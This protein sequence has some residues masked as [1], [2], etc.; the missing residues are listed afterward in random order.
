MKIILL[1]I[2]AFSLS[3]CIETGDTT[4]E[5][6]TTTN[7][8]EYTEYNNGEIL[9]RCSNGEENCVTYYKDYEDEIEE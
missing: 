9:V 6:P 3:A 1:T 7:N 5:S 4:V 2:I 8:V